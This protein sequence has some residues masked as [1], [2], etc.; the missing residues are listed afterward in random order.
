MSSP[1]ESFERLLGSL[2]PDGKDFERVAKWFLENEP[3]W[4][5]RFRRVW[6]WGEWPGRWGPDRGIDLIAASH[7]G[8]IVAIQAKNYGAD[9]SITKRD[10]DTFLSE[11]GQAPITRR[12][13]IATTDRISHSGRE[14]MERQE[15]PVSTCPLEDLRQS[16][17]AWPT[18]IDELAPAELA[19]LVPRQDQ[20]EALDAIANWAESAQDR[21]QVIRACGTGKTLIAAWAANLLQAKRVL[22]LVPTLSLLRQTAREWARS[23]NVER[24]VEVCSDRR[25][26][27]T[28]DLTAGDELGT[29]RTTD[30]EAIARALENDSPLLMLCTYNSSPTLAKAMQPAHRPFD[31]AVADEAHR[32]S[33]LE[34]S[35]HKTILDGDAI[36]ATRRL[37]F[38]ATPTV[39]GSRDK[40]RA[41]DRG[42]PLASMDDERLFGRRIHHLSFSEAIERG[43]LCRYQV[44]VIPVDSEEVFQL[45]KQRRLVSPEG[46]DG[47]LEAASLATQIA[48]ARAMRLYGCKRMVAFHASIPRS[49]QFSRQ[50]LGAAA[51]LAREDRPEGELWSEHVDGAG[52]SASKRRRL[53][54]A[55]EAD[56]PDQHRLLS[57]VKLLA[58]GVDIPDIDAVAFVDTRRGQASIIQAVGRAVRHA[59]G[60][61]VGTVVLPV[62]VR[63]DED[64]AAAIAR[65]EHRHIVDILGALRSHD[66]DIARSLDQLRF[67]LG[68]QPEGS[69]SGRFLV[70]AAV[71][72]GT[73]FATAI[74]V[75]LAEALG[76]EAPARFHVTSRTEPRV[77]AEPKRP[78]TDEELYLIGLDE[79]EILGR[80]ELLPRVPETAGGFPLGVWWDEVKR[81]WQEGDVAPIDRRVIANAVSWLAPDLAAH[82]RIRE[83]MVA[84]TD[85]GAPEQLLAQLRDGGVLA[86]KELAPLVPHI[87]AG[88]DLLEPVRTVHRSLTHAGTEPIRQVRILRAALARMSDALEAASGM[89]DE[90]SWSWEL[91]RLAA[92]DGFAHALALAGADPN[93]EPPPTPWRSYTEPEAY[94]IG[95]KAAPS[96]ARMA[97][98][99]GLFSFFGD[100]AAVARR[101][102]EE[103]GLAPD[104]RFDALGWEIF[105]LAHKRLPYAEAA[106]LASMSVHPLSKRQRIREDVERSV[107][108]AAAS[109]SVRAS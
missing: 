60:K 18:R 41:A 19:A 27:E 68:P 1:N 15:K 23:A 28:E 63:S 56:E 103:L 52:M 2:S 55:F 79:L 72:V 57:N 30:P 108:A 17:I 12:L 25:S 80:W 40:S 61:D 8:D 7:D 97:Q 37:F 16:E 66:P 101:R 98:T 75:A 85:A 31:L 35:A 42:V 102:Q 100:E 95:V 46:G 105:L 22:V 77:V 67:G 76:V 83:E 88:D 87:E 65:S 53:M 13:L 106:D 73:E 96:L 14:V 44:A 70:D 84:I 91:P 54:D 10:V 74:G 50:F 24:L 34:S 3:V 48:C 5:A 32:C 49:K 26:S 64:L 43:L 93:D 29:L 92:A 33:G 89:L 39:Y 94:A 69:A 58:E 36:R 20:Q 4:K 109:D 9:H 81:R 62:V 59:E 21:A 45:I 90:D 6:L 78:P 47:R 11:S 104:D 71:D 86:R 82:R 51:L 99:A 38:T 107:R